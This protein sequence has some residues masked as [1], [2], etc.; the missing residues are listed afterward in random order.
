MKHY[1]TDKT[2]GNL[3]SVE[4]EDQLLK[5]YPDGL[6]EVD[7]AVAKEFAQYNGTHSYDY[8]TGEWT[9]LESEE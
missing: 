5:F 7:E 3:V 4:K 1:I 6:I 9:G 2:N 8:D